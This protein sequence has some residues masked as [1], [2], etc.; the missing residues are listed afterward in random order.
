MSQIIPTNPAHPM[1]EI[2]KE[3]EKIL[4]FNKTECDS[5]TGKLH[6]LWDASAPVT[7]IGQ[8]TFFIDFLKTAN[9]YDSWVDDCPL[10]RTSPNASSKR[11]VL[12][13]IF[14]IILIPEDLIA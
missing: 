14:L 6:V 9:L 11:D 5:L 4:N 7:P 8:L 1:G 12:G 3:L 10:Q 13:T 2:Q